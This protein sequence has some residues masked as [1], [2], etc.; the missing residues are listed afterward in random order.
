MSGLTSRVGVLTAETLHRAID[1]LRVHRLQAEEP[2]YVPPVCVPPITAY[3]Q[4]AD[5]L[6]VPRDRALR[7]MREE[8][9]TRDK[10]IADRVQ[11]ATE[12]LREE[13]S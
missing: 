10:P 11:A 1:R 2:V 9:W 13:A 3:F 7:I 5:A 6:G 4:L 12:R 8:L